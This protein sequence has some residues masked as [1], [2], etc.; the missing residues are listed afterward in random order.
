MSRSNSS[1]DGV[2][3][4]RVGRPH[5]LDGAVYVWPDTDDPH[6]FEPGARVM[7]A[8]R[9]ALQ[10]ERTRTH[11]ERLLVKFVEVSDRTSAEKLRG[12]ELYIEERQR[13]PLDSEEFWP[14]E[15]EGLEVRTAR[16]KVVGRVRGVE[17]SEAQSRLVIETPSGLREVPFV[18]ELVPSVNLPD[19][20]LILVDLPGLL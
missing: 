8:G 20:Y 14:D 2:V 3:V 15:L 17:W 11:L 18:D 1:T 19:G 5:G 13:R 10:V 6:R 16:G 9:G 7:V 4:G 12:A